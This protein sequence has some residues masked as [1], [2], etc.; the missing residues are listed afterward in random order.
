MPFKL[1]GSGFARIVEFLAGPRQI[2]LA[3]ASDLMAQSCTSVGLGRIVCSTFDASE[4]DLIGYD[5]S[6]D[7]IPYIVLIAIYCIF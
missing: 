2:A 7:E 5:V 1:G 6:V 3:V 4:G